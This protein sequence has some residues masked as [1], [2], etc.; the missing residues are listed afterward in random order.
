MIDH[1]PYKLFS[2]KLEKETTSY[3]ELVVR[4]KTEKEVRGVYLEDLVD[5]DPPDYKPLPP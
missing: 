2:V 4:A 1:G 5:D 3:A